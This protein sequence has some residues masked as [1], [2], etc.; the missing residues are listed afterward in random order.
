MISYDGRLSV[1][2]GES[3]G[4]LGVASGFQGPAGEAPGV[5]V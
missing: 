1:V 5:A 4:G 2:G 3:S